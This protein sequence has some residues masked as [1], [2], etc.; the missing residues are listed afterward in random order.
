MLSA[1]KHFSLATTAVLCSP[2]VKSPGQIYASC[3][4]SELP[5]STR[6]VNYQCSTVFFMPYVEMQPCC[7]S[8]TLSGGS[9]CRPCQL[10]LVEPEHSQCIKTTVTKNNE[11]MPSCCPAPKYQLT[12]HI[13]SLRSP[14]A[15]HHAKKVLASRWAMCGAATRALC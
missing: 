7:T 5:A 12:K 15:T 14:M 9:P 3:A 1:L 11:S 4:C 8:G 10:A 13:A 6:S 2:F